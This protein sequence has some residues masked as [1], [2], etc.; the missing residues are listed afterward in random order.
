[1]RIGLIIY[2]SL[3][4]LTG[5]YIYDR[6]LVKHLSGHKDDVEIISLPEKSFMHHLWDNLSSQLLHHLEDLDCELLLQDELNHPSLFRL[7]RRL[8]EKVSYPIVSIVHHLRCCEE[9]SPLINPFYRLVER[10]YLSS[11][12]GFVCNSQATLRSVTDLL[13]TD[14]SAFSEPQNIPCIAA[15]PGGDRLHPQISRREIRG[16][17]LQ[18]GAMR[19]LFV[20][21]IIPRK[22]LHVLLKSLNGLNGSVAG[23]FILDVV[24][25]TEIDPS[26]FGSICRQIKRD[27]LTDCVRFKGI[28]SDSE[29]AGCMKASHLLVM[30]S[31]YEGFG[32]VYLEGMGF[33]LPA[34]GTNCGGTKEIIR[35]GI[36]G[37]LVSP[38]DY[39]ALRE[40]LTRL[41]KDRELLSEMSLAALDHYHSQP[42][43]ENSM[44]NIRTF[45][46]GL[47]EG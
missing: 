18:E 38:G 6:M 16:R 12:T 19:L 32:I 10:Q 39:A 42:T 7:N 11:L 33:G 37:F 27:G 46:Q 3:D 28:L 21:N 1:M 31:F 26:Y 25:D 40:H 14:V 5:G 9:N 24:G 45:L 34:I 47:I 23:Q 20:G 36:D 13:S 35:H 4:S 44:E 43:W 30:P 2:G 29:L 17:V 22:G 8:R 15:N 41:A